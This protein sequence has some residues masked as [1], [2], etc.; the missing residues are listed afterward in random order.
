MRQPLKIRRSTGQTTKPH[1][2]WVYAISI[3]SLYKGKESLGAAGQT[4]KLHLIIAATLKKSEGPKVKLLK[5]TDCEY[6]SYLSK[7]LWRKMVICWLLH[8]I[9]KN[10]RVKLQNS[11]IFFLCCAFGSNLEYIFRILSP[12]VWPEFYQTTKL[13]SLFHEFPKIFEVNT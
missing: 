13:H 5:Y 2:F 11:M 8:N 6:M 9:R 4:T 12:K 10:M 7:L 3:N 1:W